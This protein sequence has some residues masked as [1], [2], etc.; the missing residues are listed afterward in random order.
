MFDPADVHIH[1]TPESHGS[2]VNP[3]SGDSRER[4]VS[5]NRPPRIADGPVSKFRGR[6][7]NERVPERVEISTPPALRSHSS[8]DSGDTRM[9]EV[10]DVHIQEMFERGEASGSVVNT[11]NAFADQIRLLN[12][13]V[14]S[15]RREWRDE[16]QQM[17]DPSGC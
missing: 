1:S 16:N 7:R 4:G 5:P 2:N 14:S 10:F 9:K 13:Q 6:A 12:G 17:K 8:G 15:M 11:L 3:R